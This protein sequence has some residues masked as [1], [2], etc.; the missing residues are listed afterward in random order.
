MTDNIDVIVIDDEEAIIPE[1]LW[2]QHGT[3]TLQ[4]VKKGKARGKE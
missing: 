3:K 4:I 1:A 2:S